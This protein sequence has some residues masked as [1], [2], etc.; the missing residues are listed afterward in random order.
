MD[1][2]T[3]RSKQCV[4]FHYNPATHR[5]FTAHVHANYVHARWQCRWQCPRFAGYDQRT[6]PL[7]STQGPQLQFQRHIRWNAFHVQIVRSG[8]GINLNGN[9][10]R[11]F[12]DVNVFT[13]SRSPTAQRLRYTRPCMNWNTSSRRIRTR[14]LP[15]QDNPCQD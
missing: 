8:I 7:L 12:I 14:G 10:T 15:L 5:E 11:V 3:V 4:S 2:R 9:I 1:E 6:C 13:R